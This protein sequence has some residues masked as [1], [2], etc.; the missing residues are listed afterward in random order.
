MLAQIE[1]LY[2]LRGVEA[3][4]ADA[5][6]P[7]VTVGTKNVVL[8]EELVRSSEEE[9]QA[10][11]VVQDRTA[12]QGVLNLLQEGAEGQDL[13]AQELQEAGPRLLE[14][15]KT[16]GGDDHIRI[17]FIFYICKQRQ[18]AVLGLP[19]TQH[20]GL[21]FQELLPEFPSPARELL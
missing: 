13:G 3:E 11:K 1:T 7:L 16:L 10:K 19:Q 14:S 21:G 18:V 6:V 8:S 12:E 5:P 15:P 2:A 4:Q 20:V 17:Q 9:T